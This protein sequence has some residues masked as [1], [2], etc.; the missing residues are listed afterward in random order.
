MTLPVS[1]L[2]G[3]SNGA[4]TRGLATVIDVS[5]DGFRYRMDT[6]RVGFMIGGLRKT[7]RLGE[8]ILIDC[9]YDDVPL[10]VWRINVSG[11]IWSAF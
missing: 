6:G 8:T 1:G 2:S 5:R 3:R 11:C 7:P 9:D 4:I 10:N